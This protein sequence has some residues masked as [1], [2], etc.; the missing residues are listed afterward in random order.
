MIS[1]N[2]IVIENG[3]LYQLINDN[4]IIATNNNTNLGI[5]LILISHLIHCGIQ[6][7]V[8]KFCET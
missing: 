3:K 2:I 1:I 8:I 5:N 4:R 7:Y 6:S